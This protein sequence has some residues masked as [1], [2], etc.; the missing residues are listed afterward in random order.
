[1][2]FTVESEELELNPNNK[3]CMEAATKRNYENEG[4]QI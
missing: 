2:K 4:T 1:M 3:P